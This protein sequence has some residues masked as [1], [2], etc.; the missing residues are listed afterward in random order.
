MKKYQLN[1]KTGKMEE[2]VSSN[3]KTSTTA[4][5]TGGKLTAGAVAKG[6]G[7]FVKEAVLAP[8]KFLVSP[9]AML[10][11]DLPALIKGKPATSNALSRFAFNKSEPGTNQR[12]GAA[13]TNALTGVTSAMGLGGV[14]TAAAT[15]S[16]QGIIA[17]AK[18]IAK[19]TIR[20][21]PVDIAIGAG[22]GTASGLEQGRTGKD[23]FKD[24]AI[25]GAIGLA[26]PLVLGAGI[27]GIGAVAG[28]TSKMVGRALDSEIGNLEKKITKLKSGADAFYGPT[29]KEAIKTTGLETR[30]ENLKWV[31][32]IPD[33]FQTQIIDKFHP[34]YKLDKLYKT[35]T[36]KESGFLEKAQA[37]STIGYQ[38][39]DD[40]VRGVFIPM[41]QET[42]EDWKYV[43]KYADLLDERDRINLGIQVE[44]NRKLEQNASDLAKLTSDAGIKMPKIIE[45]HTKVRKF[46]NEELDNALESGTISQEQYSNFLRAHPN[47]TPNVV[48][49]FLDNPDL[50]IKR[51]GGG[52]SRSKSGYYKAE[53]SARAVL[54]SDEAI[55]Q[56]VYDWRRAA[57]LNR[58]TRD[59]V[60]TV[61]QAGADKFGFKGIWTADMEKN[62]VE[63]LK[64]LK[65]LSEA[66]KLTG[67]AKDAAWRGFHH[68]VRKEEVLKARI[69]EIG[70][71]ARNLKSMATKMIGRATTLEERG[72]ER[73][74]Q[75]EAR[76]QSLLA[77][78]SELEQI[79]D[80][81]LS[82]NKTLGLKTSTERLEKKMVEV[83]TELRLASETMTVDE[84]KILG[85][86][87]IN[88]QLT[89]FK[90]RLYTAEA[91]NLAKKEVTGLL[92]KAT[93]IGKEASSLMA[94][95]AELSHEV[96][97]A[98]ELPI[99]RL[100]KALTRL[101]EKEAR[102]LAVGK[103][104]AGYKSAIA[105]YRETLT[106]LIAARKELRDAVPTKEV[107]KRIDLV[108]GEGETI[109]FFNG[110][111]KETWKVPKEI[112][113]AMRGMDPTES[114]ALGR[115]LDESFI[116]KT[117]I[118]GPA[119]LI[120]Q[121][122]TEYNPFFAAVSNPIRDIQQAF[123]TGKMSL[124]DWGMTFG[125][126]IIGIIAPKSNMAKEFALMTREAKVRGGLLG[127]Y[128]SNT[129]ENAQLIR[130]AMSNKS[131]Y[132]RFIKNPFEVIPAIGT[133]FEETTRKAVFF[134]AL[135]NT[136]NLEMAAKMARNATVDFSRS[137]SVTKVANKVM[138][139][140]NARV[141]GL[142]V[143]GRTLK[144]DPE[145][146][147][148]RMMISAAY[149]TALLYSHNS[150]YESYKMI[151]DWEKQKFWI[152]MVG[153][154]NGKD[155]NGKSKLVPNY[156][157]IS[158]GEVQTVV[159]SVVERTLSHGQE[160]Y[161][162]TTT[163]FLQDLLGNVSP[164]T[165]ASILPTFIQYPVELTTNYSFFRGKN[166]EPEYV[167]GK[168]AE[169]L[170]PGLR[171]SYDTSAVATFLGKTLNWS[172]AKIDYVIKTGALNDVLRAYDLLPFSSKEPT[173][174]N[175]TP[176]Q[177]KS[178]APYLRSIFGASNYGL[179]YKQKE[180][181]QKATQEKNAASLKKTTTRKK[182]IKYY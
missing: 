99:E 130:E 15:T 93:N 166:I 175:A 52:L 113:Q 136:G 127:G 120:R 55:M 64:Q 44:G 102:L 169:D 103:T 123:V 40:R 119:K 60:A 147:M 85:L 155:F 16:R 30:L 11:E 141:Q 171:T 122:S 23:L 151:P 84:Q 161:P 33:K 87:V 5:S 90:Q 165:E 112:G 152:I 38:E 133:F 71:F 32:A 29:G 115:W 118:A 148:R 3:T 57:A 76:Q 142:A 59:I 77:K 104:K 69:T 143:L 105:E 81:A 56:K 95:T 163:Q 145:G 124:V 96:L 14:A 178:L 34:V 125:K 24:A 80:D 128:F 138:P 27:R 51:M 25:G 121:L 153:E 180:A 45:T 88:D 28:G 86:E 73:G 2:V 75:K 8:I 144:E 134:R 117:F 137:G 72:L 135:K 158:K 19:Q 67:K 110:G 1:K 39:A 78:T 35:L 129:K 97:A 43:N 109:S 139:F 160:E 116:G 6:T 164:V 140:L 9:F 22:F 50:F 108:R 92:Q 68:Q 62:K 83:E 17:G 91:G 13:I 159:S 170:P 41:I 94:K 42:G 10:S 132:S 82:A 114:A 53:G 47:Y 63:I 61:K 70:M 54:R 176:F 111:V 21:A 98:A 131:P 173:N 66:S 179:D 100:G 149:P 150:S 101:S 107:I 7:N 162:T 79:A 172:P 65:A 106:E 177:A 182:L 12:G 31:R 46:L 4:T 157:K 37:A 181:E 89:K 146:A 154:E 36:G 174:A 167:N 156:I 18:Q 20:T 48:V 168:R 126:G 49:D 26:A 58:A 74:L